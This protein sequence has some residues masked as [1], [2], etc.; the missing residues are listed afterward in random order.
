MD[1][2]RLIRMAECKHGNTALELLLRHKAHVL[3]T[4]VVE[5]A[6]RGAVRA[7]CVSAAA[8]PRVHARTKDWT[9]VEVL[10]RHVPLASAAVAI[11]GS[12]LT[13]AHRDEDRS[14]LYQLALRIRADC[15]PVGDAPAWIAGLR[16]MLSD[17]PADVV[18]VVMDHAG[19]HAQAL[20]DSAVAGVPRSRGALQHHCTLA[21][22][23]ASAIDAGRVAVTASALACVPCLGS[24]DLLHTILGAIKEPLQATDEP[25]REC[26]RGV[27]RAHDRRLAKC[28]IARGLVVTEDLEHELDTIIRAPLEDTPNAMLVFLVLALYADARASADMD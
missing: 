7:A 16:F 27:L 14:H 1:S 26:V 25:V 10:L 11:H 24:C 23:L 20:F 6:L 2:K 9:T 8:W 28:L 3:A 15:E 13:S 4:N 21:R 5:E 12:T 19:A 17:C 18:Q 22:S